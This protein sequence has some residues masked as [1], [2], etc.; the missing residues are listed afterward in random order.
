MFLVYIALSPPCVFFFLGCFL[1]CLLCSRGKSDLFPGVSSCFAV[2]LPPFAVCLGYFAVDSLRRLLLFPSC[3]DG[4][5]TLFPAC[6]VKT[7][8]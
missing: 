4:G 3:V 5:T 8:L 6:R 2:F 7:V 1:V